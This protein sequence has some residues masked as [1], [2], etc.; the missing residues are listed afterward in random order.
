MLPNGGIGHL[1]I[2][3][4]YGRR[5]PTQADDLGVEV[6]FCTGL[7]GSHARFGKAYVAEFQKPLD[8]VFGD[9]RKGP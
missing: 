7:T 2:E 5:E 8:G 6:A 9:A 3:A 1:R 4:I